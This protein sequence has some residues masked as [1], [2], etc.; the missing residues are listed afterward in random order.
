M[1]VLQH[2]PECYILDE[3][4]SGIDPLMQ[5][6]FW[7]TL[8]E[9]QQ[10]GATIL[11]FSHVL[12]EVKRCCNRA[13]IIKEGG[14]VIEDSVEHLTQTNTKKLSYTEFSLKI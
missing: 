7:K 5:N 6:L 14:I 4:T 11:V 2:Q 3:P 9:R 8:L 13:A 12:S 10:Q 1:C